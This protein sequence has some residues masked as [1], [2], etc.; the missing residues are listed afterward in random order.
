MDRAV[1]DQLQVPENMPS[2]PL[3]PPDPSPF[4]SQPRTLRSGTQADESS[5]SDRLSMSSLELISGNTGN[6]GSSG[7]MSGMLGYN[8]MSPGITDL[9][10][11][12]ANS[13]L[14]DRYDGMSQSSGATNL[15]MQS[16]RPRRPRTRRPTDDDV[17]PV[18]MVRPAN[19]YAD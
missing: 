11:G 17:N 16:V 2:M 12:R 13:P 1:Q 19:P 6:T 3:L 18:K 7:G 14:T 15:P 8:P 5:P 10:S 9:M 4:Q